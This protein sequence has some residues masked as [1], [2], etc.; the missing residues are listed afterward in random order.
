MTVSRAE[1]GDHNSQ[2]QGPKLP[3]QIKSGSLPAGLQGHVFVIG[4]A[5]S[6]SSPRAS[7][8]A[9]IPSK[10]GTTLLYNGD[11]MVYR[12]DFDQPDEGAF[13]ASRLVRP[14]S[15]YA[16]V[17]TY[18][19]PQFH[20]STAA[21]DLR[22]ES[23]GVARLGQLGIRNQLNTAFLPMQ[24]TDEDRERLL[25]T[26]DAGRPYEIDPATLATVTPVGWNSEWLPVSE[27][28]SLPWEPPTAFATVQTSAHPVFDP[29][30]NGGEVITV[31]L[32]RSLSNSFSQ[33]VPI[34]YLIKELID[35]IFH[36]EPAPLDL[37]R[38]VKVSPEASAVN[39]PEKE[40]LKDKLLILL[41]TLWRFIYS[42]LTFFTGNFVDLIIWDGKGQ[43]KTWRVQCNGR[44]IQINQSIHQIGVSEDYIVLLDTAFKIAVDE[45]LPPL[46]KRDSRRIEQWVRTVFDHPQL[47]RNDLYIVR[48]QD[49]QSPPPALNGKRNLP[50]VN[51]HRI[52]L[53]FEAAHFLVDYDNPNDCLTLHFSHVCAWDAAETISEFDYDLDT[54]GDPFERLYGIIYSP[55]DISRLGCATLKITP[56][57]VALVRPQNTDI[58]M[59]PK[60]TWGPAIY[61]YRGGDCYGPPGRIDT[62]YWSCIGCW[63]ELLKPHIEN[64]YKDYPY[65]QVGFDLLHTIAEAGL[66]SN[67]I[68][69]QITPLEEAKPDQSRVTIADFYQFD[70]S[71]TVGSPQFIPARGQG[72]DSDPQAG[73]LFCI[74]H[75]G[76]GQSETNG[77]EV[78]I[79]DAANLRQGP[80]CQLWHPQMDFGFTVHSTWLSQAK[81]RTANYFIPVEEDYKAVVDHPD[82]YPEV[83]QLFNDWVFP[84]REPDLKD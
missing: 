19:L 1:Y 64:L 40:T 66:P 27:L 72:E 15:Y 2:A 23:I 17:A 36:R 16:D 58:V 32:G 63:S 53:P 68:R 33:L 26:W 70:P 80:V 12:F 75:Y 57:G 25:V 14:P 52:V 6:V 79:F 69:L 39:S 9:A 5:G 76:D 54:K 81:P 34:P 56:T 24:F 61:A 18:A 37:Q 3:L 78:W 74:V 71:I 21:P 45:L 49:L 43:L 38:E 4:P 35:L 22:F 65:R 42:L 11:G 48:R 47:A 51:A 55:T 31:N 82:Q 30:R 83:R 29:H 20:G 50:T 84:Q 28:V 77:N 73:Y 67:L 44:P 8:G 59:D 41:G 62:L 60:L 46:K 7:N 10:D 13:M